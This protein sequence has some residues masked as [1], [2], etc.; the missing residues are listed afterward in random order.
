MRNTESSS[1]TMTQVT[2]II[3][4]SAAQISRLEKMEQK[5]KENSTYH[6]RRPK[7]NVRLPSYDATQDQIKMKQTGLPSKTTK[8]K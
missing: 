3:I 7:P 1:S 5:P 6:Y 2:Q 8:E 4:S